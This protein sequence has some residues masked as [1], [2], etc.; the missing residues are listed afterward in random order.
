[1][2]QTSQKFKPLVK[3]NWGFRN[4]K[5]NQK[6]TQKETVEEFLARGK[7]ITKCKS[8]LPNYSKMIMSKVIPCPLL[9][10]FRP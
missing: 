9:F 8:F 10:R 7:S 4:T 6:Q 5:K 1:M 2:T 3:G